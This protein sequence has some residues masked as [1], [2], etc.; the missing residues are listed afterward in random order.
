MAREQAPIFDIE[1][2]RSDQ[3]PDCPPHAAA[4]V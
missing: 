2:G 3:A 4:M 1:T